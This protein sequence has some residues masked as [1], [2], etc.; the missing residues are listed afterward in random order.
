MLD[1]RQSPI[2][3]DAKWAR[4]VDGG[5]GPLLAAGMASLA[6]S[7]PAEALVFNAIFD[8]QRSPARRQA[9]FLPSPT[10]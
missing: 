4:R 2:T 5:I 7:C 3:E 10:R 1:S 9:S 8:P 6:L